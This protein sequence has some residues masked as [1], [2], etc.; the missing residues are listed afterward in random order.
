MVEEQ[1]SSQ[2]SFFVKDGNAA[3]E[4]L[5]AVGSLH[6]K[7][8]LVVA[9]VACEADDLYAAFLYGPQAWQDVFR[10]VGFGYHE[11]AGPIP[12]VV[13]G[14]GFEIGMIAQPDGFVAHD[15]EVR[16][17][18]DG[19]CNGLQHG[20]LF[21]RDGAYP[22]GFFFGIEHHPGDAVAGESVGDGLFCEFLHECCVGIVVIAQGP[23]GVG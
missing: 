6:L 5:Y 3:A 4:I 9:E 14:I 19:I 15:D 12:A 16:G 2:R 23:V 7:G 22:I 17:L 13:S 10:P 18:G 11:I 20:E 1:H 8:L 21:A